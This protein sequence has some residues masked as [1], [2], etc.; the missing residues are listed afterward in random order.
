MKTKL[1][2]IVGILFFVHIEIFAQAKKPKLMVMPEYDWCIEQGYFTEFD[3]QGR[4]VKI[5][6]YD[7]AFTTNAE[8]RNAVATIQSIMADRGFPLEDMRRSGR[9][10]STRNARRTA[11]TRTASENPVDVL[12]REAKPDI[13]LDLSWTVYRNGPV[14]NIAFILNGVDAYSNK[15]IAPVEGNEVKSSDADINS[16][17]RASIINQMDAFCSKLD[18]H[19]Q[20]ILDNGREISFS[21]E[22][23]ED[24]LPDYFDT[25]FGGKALNRIVRDWVADNTVNRNF[26][27]SSSSEDYMDF[28]QVRINLY[29]NNG[30]NALDAMTWSDGLVDMLENTCKLRTKVDEVGLGRVE[31]MIIK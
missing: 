22:I 3:N 19:F 1:F 6:D 9:N 11:R 17:V 5:P 24:A 29:D 8:L 18:A 7:E 23:E 15:A 12:L 21:I 16:L 10:V 2:I 25:R 4:K 30:L 13:V 26:S 27:V 14:R 20:G 31:I 28:D